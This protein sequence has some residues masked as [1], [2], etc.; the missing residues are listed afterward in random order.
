MYD[1][2]YQA[3]FEDELKK[4]AGIPRVGIAKR[5]VK[6]LK[7][8]I[9]GVDTTENNKLFEKSPEFKNM[10]KMQRKELKQIEKY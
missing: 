1:K 5:T 2:I 4:I 3:A 6:L 7:D 8:H 10:Q 9:K